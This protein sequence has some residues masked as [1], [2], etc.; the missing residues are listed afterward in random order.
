MKRRDFF[1]FCGVAAAGTA[2][3]QMNPL[4]AMAAGAPPAFN[5][6]TSLNDVD[7][8]IRGLSPKT[9]R[10]ITIIIIGAG[11]R[12]NTYARYAQLFPD[13]VKVVGVSDINDYRLH[14]LSDLHDV[15]VER[16]YGDF[17]EILSVPKFADAAVICTPDDVH[18]APTMMALKLGYHVLVEKPIAPTEKECRD[19]LN[20]SL[21]SGL[22]V[23]TCH[24][25]R[26]AP[27]FIALRE[28]MHRGMIGDI[29]S[30]QHQEPIQFQHMA[31]SYVRGNWRNEKQTT[32]I[33]LAKS[34]HDL[35]ILRWLF[36]KPCKTIVADG[37]LFLFKAENA[38]EGAPLKCTDGC[39]HEAACPYSAINIYVREKRHTYV[40]DIPDRRDEAA[41]L[42]QLKKGPYGRC[43]YHCD[44][45]QPDHY[46]ANMVFEGGR[47][48]SFSMDAFAPVGGRRTRVMGTTG[49]IDGDGAS[50]TL[51]DFRDG[52]KYVWDRKVSDIPEYKGSG[53]GGGDHALFRDFTEAVAANDPKLL[54]STIDVSME[55][56][57]M[58]FLAEKSRKN[59]KKMKIK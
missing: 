36:D 22:V 3:S 17:S 52:K 48:A 34:C 8:N 31:H 53:H 13:K 50:F 41:L 27:Y 32:P 21:K 19:I 39:P 5:D 45:D 43:V 4:E 26:Y 7:L 49:F 58:G 18:Y 42:D 57:L 59:G 46:V 15:P 38:P 1:K 14:K 44:N 40:F 12:G 23:G 54:S 2:L 55:S 10:Q 25:L 6:V 24:V 51:W 29:V 56:H 11:S 20:L 16:R 30:I 33:I 35:D 47:T 37:D 28:V 9:D